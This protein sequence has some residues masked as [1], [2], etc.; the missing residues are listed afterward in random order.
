M[1]RTRA[2][3]QLSATSNPYLD[4]TSNVTVDPQLKSVASR[5]NLDLAW[6]RLQTSTE[7][8]YRE[9]FRSIYR[10]FGIAAGSHLEVIRDALLGGYYEPAVATKAY[11]P[12]KS[13]LQRVFTLISVSD[14]V[15]YQA[16]ANIVADKLYRRT[17]HLYSY[18]IFGHRYAGPQSQ[19]FYR[20][21]RRSYRSYAA[22]MRRAF[23]DG[24]EFTASFDLTA[25][26]DS[27]D[28]RVLEHFLFQL[29]I[30][31][32]VSQLLCTMLRKW[33]DAGY[34]KPILHGHGLPQGPLPSGM[35]AEVVL[36]HFDST[37]RKRGLRYFRYVDDIRLFARDERILRQELIALDIKSKEVGLFPQS[38]KVSIHR[39][40]NIEDEIKT[41][42]QP[43]TEY[44]QQPRVDQS[45]LKRAL[46]ALS[47]RFR[48][49]K[50]TQ[51]K[52]DLGSAEPNSTLVLRLLRIV[53]RD[54]SLYDAICRY[55]AR[56]PKLSP[57]ASATFLDVLRSHDL[58]PGFAAAFLRA[59]RENI[60]E[61][62]QKN[63]FGYCRSRLK[64]PRA[65]KSPELRAAA[66]ATLLWNREMGWA[67][68]KYTLMWK[69]SW[70]FRAW[71]LGFLQ[72]DHIGPPSFAAL[73]HEMIFDDSN[74]VALIAAE[75]LI[76]HK[77]SVPQP[78]RTINTA[79]Q[80]T[81]REV[82]KIGR[83]QTTACPIRAKMVDTLGEEVRPIVWKRVL[84]AKAYTA[85]RTRVAVWSSYVRSD[86][87]AWVVL[88]DT[89]NDILLNALFAHDTTIGGYSLGNIGGALQ[90]Q[91]RFA[92]KYP[93]LYR[94]VDRIHQLRLAADLAH[95]ITRSTNIPTHRI[96]FRDMRRLIGPLAT[97]YAEM[98]QAW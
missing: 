82:G 13:G 58:Y 91:S 31:A 22:A 29:G 27:I 45:K 78:I 74:D 77:L 70:W 24:Y 59:S 97:G 6:L 66:A 39:V 73:I 55:I 4:P 10:A 44:S 11:F 54:P 2:F 35:F 18:N 87:T 98:W 79:A 47:P 51:F 61:S 90:A 8:A 23:T 50:L 17:K 64:G 53:D 56:C 38:S 65:S 41:I 46:V 92:Q 69:P 33:T 67:E 93:R 62:A 20:D 3:P 80:R 42:S 32:E 37:S 85:M 89:M 26:Y 43:F 16:I 14:H 34:K 95:P 40:T 52:Y 72:P 71:T 5:K 86:A 57:K 60:H 63:L 68:S 76:T 28:H 15:V 84:D 36:S 7:R 19:Y 30:T 94:I 88:T 81:L 1:S 83:V 9:Y 96:A 21:W 75:L 12:K 48:V 49:E 25:C